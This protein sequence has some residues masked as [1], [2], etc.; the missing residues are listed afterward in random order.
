[1]FTDA[2]KSPAELQK[3]IEDAKRR[4]TELQNEGQADSKS[5]FGVIQGGRDLKTNLGAPRNMRSYS[6]D[7]EMMNEMRGALGD[8][9]NNI[10]TETN[11]LGR[12]KTPGVESA[13]WGLIKRLP[14][15]KVLDFR[16]KNSK[17]SGLSEEVTKELSKNKR[18]QKMLKRLD[19]FMEYTGGTVRPRKEEPV[20]TFEDFMLRLGMGAIFRLPSAPEDQR[21]RDKKLRCEMTL[22]VAVAKERDSPRPVQRGDVK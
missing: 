8:E 9:I 1:M 19:E 11:W 18:H 4:Y 17:E 3:E 10:Y 20:E 6:N 22:R 7:L 13:D 21:D 12:V 15:Y 5:K 16:Y 2:Q 14:A